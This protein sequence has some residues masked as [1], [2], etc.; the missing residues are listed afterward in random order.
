[1]DDTVLFLVHMRDRKHL[2]V[3]KGGQQTVLTQLHS[4]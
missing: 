3:F 4:F 2:K 1:M